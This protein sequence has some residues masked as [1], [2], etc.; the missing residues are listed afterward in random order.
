MDILSIICSQLSTAKG[1]QSIV[2]GS[3][4]RVLV[5]TF[6]KIRE[7]YHIGAGSGFQSSET[8]QPPIVGSQLGVYNNPSFRQSLQILEHQMDSLVDFVAKQITEAKAENSKDIAASIV[9]EIASETA[10]EVAAEMAAEAHAEAH[11]EA[12]S[13]K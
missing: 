5:G 7:N 8:W 3:K 6:R 9:S 10:A 4:T 2:G 11:A 13:T 12:A 1:W